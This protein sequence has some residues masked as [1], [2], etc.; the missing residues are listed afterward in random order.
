MLI[1]K[2]I[3]IVLSGLFI[4]SQRKGIF[5]NIAPFFANGCVAGFTISTLS[6][7]LVTEP[8]TIFSKLLDKDGAL[9]THP[10]CDCHVAAVIDSKRFLNSEENSEVSVINQVSRHRLKQITGNRLRSTPIVS[11]VFLGCRNIAL[12]SHHDDGL[13]QVDSS[14]NEGKAVAG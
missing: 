9:T 7:K 11:I 10:N 4:W 6:Q 1:V 12:H 5:V 3:W 13:L 14:I 2:N 8:L